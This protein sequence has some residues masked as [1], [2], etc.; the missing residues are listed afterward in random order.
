MEEQMNK[1]KKRIIIAI[2]LSLFFSFTGCTI[3]AVRVYSNFFDR[4]EKPNDNEFSLSFYWK[5]IDQSIY[6]REEIFFSSGKNRLQG[7]VYGGSNENGLIVISGGLGATADDYLP[8][9]MFFVDNGWRVFAFNNTGVA[10]SEGK[11]TRGLT[12]SVIDLDAALTFIENSTEFNGLSIMLVGHSWGGYAVCAVLNY[13]HRINA[14]AS[15]A[16][17]N[18]GRDVYDDFGTKAVGLRY[19]MLF[20]HFRVIQ[21]F[22]FGRAVA[23]NAVDGINKANI[24]VMIVHASNDDQMPATTTSIYAYRNRISN[25]FTEVIFLDGDDATGHIYVFYSKNQREYRDFLIKSWKAYQ[26]EHENV[27]RF[28]WAQEINF[29]KVLANE[30]NMELM[31]TINNFFSNFKETEENCNRNIK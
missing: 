9:I 24:P 19:Y 2:Y 26:M 23:L 20:P 6:N 8:M 11:S 27:S 4:I 30:L 3:I 14:V 22:H 17:Y 29:E 13:D 1:I 12:Q 5:D 18:N 10:G 15:F 25:P 31:N 16:G 7:F 28:Q 21:R